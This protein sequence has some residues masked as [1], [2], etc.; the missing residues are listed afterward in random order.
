[1]RSASIVLVALAACG[2]S[3]VPSTGFGAPASLQIRTQEGTISL[4]VQV[5]DEDA[6]R[7]WGLMGRETLA[8]H[9]G[10]AFVWDA[11]VE[12]SFWMKDTPLPLSIAFWDEDGAIVSILDMAPCRADPCPT[13]G[14]GEPFVG[15]LEVERGELE[16]RG[17]AL[18]DTVELTT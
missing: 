6:E 10:M 17:V 11:P 12:T 18:G 14:P 2:G 15:A 8:P 16:R 4:E 13:Y 7:A 9:D 5:A 1:M 3:S